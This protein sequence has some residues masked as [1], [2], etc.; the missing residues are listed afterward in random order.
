MKCYPTLSSPFLAFGLFVFRA[1]PL[2]I[3]VLFGSPDC[4]GVVLDDQHFLLD[5]PELAHAIDVVVNGP[6]TAWLEP[7]KQRLGL[8]SH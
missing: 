2:K 1:E 8:G 4:G 7:R 6:A 3:Q 5:F